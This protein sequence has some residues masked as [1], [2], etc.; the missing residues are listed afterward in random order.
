MF[1]YY[2]NRLT[3]ENVRVMWLCWKNKKVAKALQALQMKYKVPI[4]RSRL[5][6]LN[7]VNIIVIILFL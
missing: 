7:L 6:R 2:T 5:N 3:K 4:D 1:L